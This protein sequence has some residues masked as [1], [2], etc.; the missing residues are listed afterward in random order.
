MKKEE[1]IAKLKEIEGKKKTE[2]YYD[3]EN[4]HG[5]ADA[6]LLEFINDPEIEKAYDEVEKWYA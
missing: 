3:T 5:E 2:P 6:L 1:L 4:G